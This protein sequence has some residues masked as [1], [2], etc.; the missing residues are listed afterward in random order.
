MY[1]IHLT[2]ALSRPTRLQD[3]L[4][5]IPAVLVRRLMV[6]QLLLEIG[7]FRRRLGALAG[8]TLVD[9]VDGDVDEPRTV[10]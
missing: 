6:M 1:S 2:N 7:N 9:G 4:Q 5:V 3:L 10:K 8:K